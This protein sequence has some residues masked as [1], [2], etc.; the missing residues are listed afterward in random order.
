MITYKVKTWMSER[1]VIKA[2][3]EASIDPL[4]KAAL[5]VQR[6]AKSSLMKRGGR[7]VG[8]R[9]GDKRTPSPPGSPPHRQKGNLVGSVQISD[10]TWKGTFLVGP[11]TK[12]WYGRIHEFG[13]RKHPKRPFMRPAL[14]K[15][16]GRFPGLFKN[17]RLARTPA[18]I[19]LNAARG[20]R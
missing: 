17:L 12:A 3:K 6:E 1:Q 5:L 7:S 9:G 14:Y 2:T 10:P 4:H 19:R 8:P 20:P 15:T 13:G 16:K 11:T 18:G